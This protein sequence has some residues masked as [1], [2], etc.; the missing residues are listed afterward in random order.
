MPRKQELPNVKSLPQ[1]YEVKFLI[2]SIVCARL[3]E[4]TLKTMAAVGK[5]SDTFRLH[6][7]K[8]VVCKT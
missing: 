8:H 3:S 4:L 5:Y 2:F 6:F 1:Q 7:V